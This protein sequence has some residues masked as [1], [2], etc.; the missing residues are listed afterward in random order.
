MTEGRVTRRLGDQREAHAGRAGH[1]PDGR[2]RMG[3]SSSASRFVLREGR[4]EMG[5]R[6]TEEEN[7][8]AAPR[9]ASAPGAGGD[10]LAAQARDL[11]GPHLRR[12]CFPAG[13]LL[14]RE[15]E[16]TGLLVALD[17]GRVKIYRLL[18]TGRAVTM[19]L[20]GPGDVFGFLPFLDGEPYPAYAQALEDTEAQVMSRDQLLSAV[21]ADPQVGIALI[22]LVGRRLREAMQRLESLSSPGV[23]PRVASALVALLPDEGRAG[24]AGI[25]R[26]PVSGSEFA[27]AIGIT[28]E[29]LSRSLT[30]LVSSRTLHRLGPG[31]FQ[32]LDPGALRQAAESTDASR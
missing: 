14:W 8:A 18:P 3:R 30:R 9:R 21:H 12:R 16:T 2:G 5:S 11:L 32:V 13:S 25:I 29:T 28:P 10:S 17:R 27:G 6:R 31:R 15:G 26:L 20:F 23:L 1:A 24:P 7:A 4:S 22:A 19:F